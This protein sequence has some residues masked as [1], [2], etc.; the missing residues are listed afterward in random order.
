MA[1]REATTE[2]VKAVAA[3]LGIERD[4]E[5]LRELVEQVRLLSRTTA[6]IDARDLTSREPAI[7]FSV[8]SG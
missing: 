1:N 7:T 2:S 8:G 3:L 6:V 4:E 5:Q